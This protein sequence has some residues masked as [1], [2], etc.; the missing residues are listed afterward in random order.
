MEVHR[1]SAEK[2]GAALVLLMVCLSASL[3]LGQ[4]HFVPAPAPPP[5]QDARAVPET[6]QDAWRTALQTDQQIESSRWNLS[7]ARSSLEAAKAERLPTL[8]VGAD[9]FALSQQPGFT[10]N[11][12]P[13]PAT[14]MS[15]IGRDSAG[16]HGLVTQPVYTFGRISS[17]INAADATVHANQ[18]DAD[19]TQLDVKIRVAETYVAVLRAARLLEVADS[20]VASLASHTTL[21]NALFTAERVPRNDLLAAQVALADARQQ[22]LEAR[23]D[24]DS[25]CA[26]YNRALGRPLA[27]RVLLAELRDDGCL[28]NLDE[29]TGRALQTRP[30]LAGLAS[31]AVALQ[32]QAAGIQAKRAPQVTLYGGYVYQQDPYINPN[33]VAAVALDLEW[34]AVDFGRLSNQAS[35]LREKAEAV[36]RTRKD[37]EFVID[38]E[39][40]QRWLDL[41]TARQRIQVAWQATAQADENLRIA[42]GRYEQQAGTNTEVL[43]AQTSRVQAYTNF[44]N[45]TYQAVLAGMRL[46]RAVGNL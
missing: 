32:E 46:R 7:S 37:A 41:Q 38:L 33:G 17:G 40:R 18:A 5:P 3:A 10:L 34:T 9:Y 13:L 24:Y 44:Y 43:D 27:A 8:K 4:Q 45:C 22:Q 1:A 30:E 6:L 15:L 39:V 36:S 21:V 25:A 16:F 2:V 12:P 28:G 14:Q 19:Q 42:R 29:L 11:A 20:R 31:Q 23:N 26:A 35:A